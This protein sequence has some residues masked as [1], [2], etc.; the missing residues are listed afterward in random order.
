MTDSIVTAEQIDDFHH[1]TIQA[2][3]YAEGLVAEVNQL[4]SVDVVL[5][6]EDVWTRPWLEVF[7]ESVAAAGFMLA[8]ELDHL[9]AFPRPVKD[10]LA[11]AHLTVVAF[12]GTVHRTL[13]DASS[14]DRM[15]VVTIGKNGQKNKRTGSRPRP[16]TEEEWQA[17]VKEITPYM[18]SLKEQL[19][20]VRLP[21]RDKTDEAL[22]VEVRDAKRDLDARIQQENAQAALLA[23]LQAA[24]KQT[25][26][27]ARLEEEFQFLLEPL[28]PNQ[29][30]WVL[31]LLRSGKWSWLSKFCT[32]PLADDDIDPESA[33]RAFDRIK[34]NWT[35]NGILDWHISVTKY[36]KDKKVTLTSPS[37]K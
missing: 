17:L 2:L 33:K 22:R 31:H 13:R 7:A 34:K 27:Q 15:D 11:G 14:F 12:A 25:D 19:E 20:D 18:L 26:Y 24:Q 9:T 3:I 23:A 29:R 10:A 30:S 37:D 6:P 21:D 36:G 5:P 16:T 28:T 8:E 32:A 1:R 4:R 35:D